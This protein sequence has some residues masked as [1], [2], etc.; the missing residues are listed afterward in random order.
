MESFFLKLIFLLTLISVSTSSFAQTDSSAKAKLA[1]FNSQTVNSDI[2]IGSIVEGSVNYGGIQPHYIIDYDDKAFTPLRSYAQGLKDEFDVSKRIELLKQYITS[3][4]LIHK[5]Y[6]A[7]AYV[8][9]VAQYKKAGKNIPLSSYLKGKAGVCRE[10]ALIFHMALK[11]A[12]IKNTYLY[13]RVFQGSRFEDHATNVINMNGEMRVFDIYNSNFHNKPLNTLLEP[14][15]MKVGSYAI[16]IDVINEYPAVYPMPEAQ[17]QLAK[18]S[19]KPFFSFLQSSRIRCA[20]GLKEM[21]AV[22]R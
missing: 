21:L 13:S 14:G 11:D 22:L 15:G 1:S 8:K 4:V 3:H 19:K 12:G 10:H 18:T 5:E 2:Q 17:K 9:L 6:E 7:P 20:R 16:G